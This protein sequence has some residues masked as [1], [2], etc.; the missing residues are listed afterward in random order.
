MELIKNEHYW[1]IMDG[2]S[3]VVIYDGKR[4]FDVCGPWE[5]GCGLRELEIIQHIPRPESVKD[6][7]LYYDQTPW[8]DRPENQKYQ[9]TN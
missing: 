6:L 5:C 7:N 9:N 8:E 1:A 4:G 2:K 3:L